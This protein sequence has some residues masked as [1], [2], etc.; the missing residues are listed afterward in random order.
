MIAQSDTAA[1]YGSA[2]YFSRTFVNGARFSLKKSKLVR[3][4]LRAS[5]A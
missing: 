1:G 5:N 4:F 2:F 3:F